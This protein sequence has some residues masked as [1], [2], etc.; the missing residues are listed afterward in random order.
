MNDRIGR[1]RG[2][3]AIGELR[4]DSGAPAMSSASSARLPVA[5]Y[6]VITE[7]DLTGLQPLHTVQ[8]MY[9]GGAVSMAPIEHVPSVTGEALAVGA[10]VR[11]VNMA[12]AGIAAE[13]ITTP[14]TSA[15]AT[16]PAHGHT[17]DDDGGIAGPFL[18]A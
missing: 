9:A 16:L 15:A 12:G 2:A 11:L 7:V 13:L 18:G 8:R 14:S 10:V 17:S 3:A 4:R 5:Y 1:N 6:G